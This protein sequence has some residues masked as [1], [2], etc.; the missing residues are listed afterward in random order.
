MVFK[1]HNMQSFK[2]LQ[3]PSAEDKQILEYS[4][5]NTVLLKAILK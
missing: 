4:S 3:V 2:L 5:S 1:L